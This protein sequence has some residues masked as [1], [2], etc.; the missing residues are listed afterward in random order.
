MSKL[1]SE[2]D[3]KLSALNIGCVTVLLA[4]LAGTL[5]SLAFG[6]TG[7][8]FPS[9]VQPPTIPGLTLADYAPL[10]GLFLMVAVAAGGWVAV[11]LPRKD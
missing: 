11:S 8:W 2:A 9:L 3:M 1:E 7:Q 10:V 5:L 6:F 4:A